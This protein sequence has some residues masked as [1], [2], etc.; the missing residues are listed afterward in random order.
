MGDPGYSKEYTEDQVNQNRPV[1]RSEAVAGT[2]PDD[3]GELLSE[4]ETTV[5]EMLQISDVETVEDEAYDQ[6][7]E[8]ISEYNFAEDED[9]SHIGI[10][11]GLVG[12]PGH[13]L[14]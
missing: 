10:G 4:G 11:Y 12:K 5:D 2:S 3:E 7:E 1:S 13:D 14:E 6:D 8:T 9:I